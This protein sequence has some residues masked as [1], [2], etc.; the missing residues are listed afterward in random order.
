MPTE[1]N[2]IERQARECLGGR[3]KRPDEDE[4][5]SLLS[6]GRNQRV[7]PSVE[8]APVVGEAGDDRAWTAGETVEVRLTFSEAVTVDTAGGRP[9]IGL[10]LGGTE[11]P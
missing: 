7:A 1:E 9:A 6:R 10:R 3:C 5:E 8:G 4:G 11:A 2:A